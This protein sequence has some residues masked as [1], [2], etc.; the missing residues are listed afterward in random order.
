MRIDFDELN[1][2][3]SVFLNSKEPFITLR[4][5]DFFDVEGEEENKLVFHLLLLVENGLI[6]NRHLQTGDPK[7]IG[8]IFSSRGVGGASIPIR[9][10]QDGH[11]FANALNKKPI[12]ERLKQDFADAPFEMLK[13]V[14]KDLLTSFVK[15]KLGF[16]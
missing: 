16:E 2:I 14:S 15:N 1:K 10:T 8:I 6:S 7:H 11:D 4:D 12:L 9:L 13:D 3:L 5:L